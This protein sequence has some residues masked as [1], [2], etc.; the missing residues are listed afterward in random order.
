MATPLPQD[1]QTPAG[2]IPRARAPY[3][4]EALVYALLSAALLLGSIFVM[5]TINTL[6][7]VAVLVLFQ[8]AL[9]MGGRSVM[10]HHR[11]EDEI[12][13]RARRDYADRLANLLG[14]SQSTVAPGANT[15]ADAERGDSSSE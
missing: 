2:R 12:R 5:I 4:Y 10:R 3:L 1:D 11:A 9:F 8:V 13:E 14:R 6:L 7:G 15:R